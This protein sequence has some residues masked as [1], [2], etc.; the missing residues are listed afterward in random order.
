M[1]FPGP[2]LFVGTDFGGNHKGSRYQTY[3]YLLVE[4]T[5][6][7]WLSMMR[8]IRNSYLEDSRRMSFKKLGDPQRQAALIP[9]L[10]AADALSG[11][12]VVFAVHKRVRLHPTKKGDLPDWQKRAQLSARWNHRALEEAI[13][14]V[15][16]FALLVGQWS[17]S[18]MDVTWISDEDEFVGNEKRLDD[19]QKLAAMFTKLYQP[20]GL[21]VF[22]MNTTSVDGADRYFEDLVAIPDLVGGMLAELSSALSG[23]SSWS[24]LGAE[25]LLDDEKVQAKTWLI[26]DWFWQSEAKLRKTCVILDDVGAALRVFRLDMKCIHL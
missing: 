1:A 3:A 6:T 20:H 22:A 21:G 5:P 16:F 15:H 26:S 24:D 12:L 10:D 25:N 4:D 17:S 19:A 13:R 9:F 18:K 14:K 11:H 2:H 23:N 7:R 8:E